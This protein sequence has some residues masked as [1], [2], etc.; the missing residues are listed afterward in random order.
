MPA[1]KQ[2]APAPYVRRK[3]SECNHAESFHPDHKECCAFGC[4]C[5]AWKD[6]GVKSKAKPR[7]KSK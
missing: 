1:K 5:E 4:S 2:A 7:A 6:E 3:C